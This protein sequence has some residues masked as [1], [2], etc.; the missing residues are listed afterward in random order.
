[1]PYI[2]SRLCIAGF[3]SCVQEFCNTIRIS[4]HFFY[5]ICSFAM[6]YIRE[7]GST[8]YG[9]MYKKVSIES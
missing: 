8:V 6:L 4:A 2:M 7:N 3:N 9:I 5:R 1:M